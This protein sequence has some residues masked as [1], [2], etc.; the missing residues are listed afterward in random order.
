MIFNTAVRILLVAPAALALSQPRLTRRSVG[1]ALAASSFG[2]LATAPASARDRTA[3]YTVQRSE[4]EWQYVLSGQQYGILRQGGTEAPNSSPL[5]NEKRAGTFRCAGCDAPLFSSSAKFES[6]T[7]WPSWATPLA[8]VAVEDGGGALGTARTAL[9]G[10]EARCADCG[11]HLGDLFLDGFLFP[12]TPAFASGKRYCID[13][14]ALVFVPQGEGA[15]RV[16]G[17]AP[18]RPAAEPAPLPGWLQPPAVGR[19]A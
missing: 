14:A 9:L 19:P 18:Y 3:G 6:G 2:P 7:G 4:R 8:A 13:G 17:E 11:G 16:S 1:V 5:V 15:A 10:S 12:G